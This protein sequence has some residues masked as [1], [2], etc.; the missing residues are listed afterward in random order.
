MGGYEKPFLDSLPGE[1]PV[2]R[3]VK[4]GLE[5]SSCR[6]PILLCTLGRFTGVLLRLRLAALQ[7]FACGV[8][9]DRVRLPGY[10]EEAF[11]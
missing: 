4:D 9:V 11:L 7:A 8:Y 5:A 6:P 1:K 3:G 10:H 2:R